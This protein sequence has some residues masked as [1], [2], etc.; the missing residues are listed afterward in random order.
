[1]VSH[2]NHYTKEY[3]CYGGNKFF[4]YS[5]HY[6]VC[7]RNR[8]PARSCHQGGG[9]GNDMGRA[10]VGWFKVEDVFDLRSDLSANKRF[11]AVVK[12]N[13]NLCICMKYCI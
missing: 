3:V 13:V 4:F 6:F 7:L 2:L 9:D 1:M 11:L 8:S 10:T 12:W 5:W